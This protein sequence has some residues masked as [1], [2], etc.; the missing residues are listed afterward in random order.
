[1]WQLLDLQWLQTHLAESI[2]YCHSQPPLFNVLTGVVV[3]ISPDHYYLVFHLLMLILSWASALLV[4]VTLRDLMLSWGISFST[5]AFFLLNPALLLYENLYS[6]TLLTVFLIVVITYFL[7]RFVNDRKLIDWSMFVISGGLLCLTRSSFHFIWLLLLVPLLWK[8][9]PRRARFRFVYCAVLFT[10][11]GWYVKNLVLFD[12]FSS[13]SWFGMNLARLVPLKSELGSIGPFKPLSAYPAAMMSSNPFPQVV[14]LNS[15]FKGKKYIN[16]NHH[17][18]ID[19]SRQ[20][21]W[22][23]INQIQEEPGAYASVVGKAFIAYFN[24]ST[25]APFVDKNFAVM[26]NYAQAMTLDFSTWKRY[27]RKAFSA[28][29]A[30]PAL[31]IYIIVFALIIVHGQRWLLSPPTRIVVLFLS[32]MV[33]YGMLVGNLFEYGENNRFRFETHTCFLIVAALVI[34]RFFKNF[35]NSC[36]QK[37]SM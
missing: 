14:A 10:V 25:H 21:K 5:S 29:A 33:A 34:D 32:F 17:A 15:E 6:Y 20:F 18:Y 19:V 22:D 4:F 12:T 37:D 27:D 31:V 1:M 24:P 7:V 26:N 16:F 36:R 8:N 23:V 9:F 35:R 3:K 11:V 30:L 13:S 28:T 2:W